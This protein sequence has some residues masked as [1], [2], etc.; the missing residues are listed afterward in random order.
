MADIPEGLLIMQAERA[1]IAVRAW[2]DPDGNEL[3][4]RGIELFDTAFDSPEARDGFRA[5]VRSKT[6]NKELEEII[7]HVVI[8]EPTTS[9]AAAYP[10]VCVFRTEIGGSMF[11]AR[12]MRHM[13]TLIPPADGVFTFG[14]GA[15]LDAF[16]ASYP[17]PTID[18]SLLSA[19]ALVAV[20]SALTITKDVLEDDEVGN[21]A[22][23]GDSADYGSSADFGG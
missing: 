11:V 10:S 17:N 12:D 3:A 15:L 22:D 16:H 9:N 5:V 23:Y 7:G 8:F 14:T 13:V 1:Y 20:P 21:S 2:L 19:E 6:G 18:P 4:E